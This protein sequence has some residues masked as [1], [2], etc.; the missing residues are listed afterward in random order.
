MKESGD[1]L[2]P[3]DKTKVEEEVKAAKE[4][5]E[6][7]DVSKMKEATEKLLN[8]T[9]SIFSKLYQQQAQANATQNGGNDKPDDDIVVDVSD[10]DKK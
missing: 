6:K 9:G 8:N 1:K 7:G 2:D 10:D 3:A 4:V 5:L